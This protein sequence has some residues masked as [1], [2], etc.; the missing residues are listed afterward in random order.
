MVYNICFKL[1]ADADFLEK[2][3]T[4]SLKNSKTR[5]KGVIDKCR[6]SKDSFSS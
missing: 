5:V 6:D 4:P 3:I 1:A 2:L